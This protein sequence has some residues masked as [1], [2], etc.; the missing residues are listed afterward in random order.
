MALNEP[1]AMETV[2]LLEVEGTHLTRQAPGLLLN[3]L[4]L[5][6]DEA[7]VT[8]THTMTP[9]QDAAFSGFILALLGCQGGGLLLGGF[10]RDRDGKLAEPAA[11]IVE[12]F[13]HLAVAL[14][15]VLHSSTGIGWVKG[16]EVG[17]L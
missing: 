8:L 15:A 12:L 4:L 6:L 17:K 13:P 9:I 1:L 11:V 14:P 2:D 5:A 16:G 10:D 3:G 7:A